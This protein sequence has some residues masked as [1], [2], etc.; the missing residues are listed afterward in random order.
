[1]ENKTER[2]DIIIAAIIILIFMVFSYFSIPILD[3]FSKNFFNIG[4]KIYLNPEE[5]SKEI[6]LIDIDEKSF[7]EI[8]PWP[9]PKNLIGDMINILEDSGIRLIGLNIPLQKNIQNTLLGE[10]LDFRKKIKSYPDQ[11]K[12]SAFRNWVEENLD[13]IESR[14]DGDKSLSISL[15]NSG[16]VIIPVFGHLIH[17]GKNNQEF[18]ISTEPERDVLT[19]DKLSP[20]I[21]KELAFFPLYPPE[22]DFLKNSLGNGYSAI[23]SGVDMDKDFDPLFFIYKDSILPSMALRLAIAFLE[24]QPENVIVSDSSIKIKNHIIPLYKGRLLAISNDQA[25]PYHRYSFADFININ[26]QILGVKGKIAIISLNISDLDPSSGYLSPQTQK[27]LPCAQ[28]LGNIIGDRHISRPFY[29]D[30]VECLLLLFAGIFLI[31]V[32]SRWSFPL[33]VISTAGSI[34]ILFIIGFL[35]LSFFGIWFRPLYIN[36]CLFFLFLYFFIKKFLISGFL[37]KELPETIKML[38]LSFQSQ[39]HLDMAFENFKKLPSNNE[40]KDLIF[41][42]AAEFE[43]KRMINKALEAYEYIYSK[44]DFR[45]VRNRINQ[46]KQTDKSSSMEGYSDISEESIISDATGGSR[47]KVGRYEILGELG[48]GSMGLVYKAQDPK[49]NRLVAIKTIRFSDEF[50][51]DVVSE[52]KERFFMEAEIAG[53]LSHPSIVTIHDVGDDQDLTYMAMEFLEGEDLDNYVQKD[54]LLPLRRVLDIVAKIANALDF[55]HKSEVIHRDIKPANVMLLKNGQI[56]VTDFGIAKAISSSRTKTGVILGTPN[57][58]SPEQIM[59]QKIDARSDIFSLGVLF[60]QLITG[61]LPFHGENLSGLLYQI[62]QV[63]HQSPREFNPKIPKICEQII[64]KSMA[65]NPD[66]RFK[67]AGDMEK[68]L[69]LLMKKMDE[70]KNK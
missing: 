19:P 37:L 8:G 24:Q 66:K 40:T 31:F 18:K 61:E 21:K 56:K 53:Q 26:N 57:Y 3:K 51:E 38:G 36:L 6:V 17:A 45:D 58:M 4:A 44:G 12:D 41:N 11:K 23:S 16:K 28:L 25:T 60:F 34:I 15:K 50:D 69:K 54:N 62:T 20:S 27:N 22:P 47:K 2:S 10:L 65:K 9:W 5:Q 30:Y 1:M 14:I 43:K 64:D 70:I 46:L 13:Q 29:L 67:T 48:K 59:G 39:G 35:S 42:V 32:S 52:I 49:I 63:K 33:I 68:V 55:A 7:H